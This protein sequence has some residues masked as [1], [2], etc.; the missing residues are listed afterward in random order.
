MSTHEVLDNITHQD[1]KI[2]TEHHPKYGDTHSY[3]TLVPFELTA[4]QVDY[5]IFLRKNS[6]S[7]QFELVALL[8]L[9]QQE[10]LFLDENGWHA[11]YIPLSIQRRP[12]LIGFQTQ[13]GSE[14]AVVHIDRANPRISKEK[15]EAIFMPHGGQSGFLQDITSILHTLHDGNIETQSLCKAITDLDLIES[16]SL[17]VTLNNGEKVAIEELF[18][19]KEENLAKLSG[20][21]LDGLHKQGFLQHI[22]MLLASVQNM[23]KLIERKNATLEQADS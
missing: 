17:S 21:Q 6:Q 19:I 3:T 5:P 13:D 15:G 7:K 11:H 18:T 4:A 8:G 22:Y 20:E 16:V 23:I 9:Q 10:N 1:L 2:I 14:H 12:F